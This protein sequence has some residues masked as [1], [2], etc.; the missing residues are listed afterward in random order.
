MISYFIAGINW[1]FLIFIL[2]TI[3]VFAYVVD[4]LTSDSVKQKK[5][6]KKVRRK[7]S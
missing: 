7:I 2:I 6:L 3:A 5:N 4:S 1:N